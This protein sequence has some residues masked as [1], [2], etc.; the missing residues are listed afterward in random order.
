MRSEAMQS[1]AVKG[2]PA[3]AAAASAEYRAWAAARRRERIAV[4][5]WRVLLVVA[6]LALWEAAPRLGLVNPML[7]SHPSAVWQGFLVLIEEG[8]LGLHV[9]VTVI[10]TIAAFALSMI[11][12][13]AAALALWSWPMVQKVLDPFLVVANALP[14]IALVPIFYIWLGP[15]Q[16]IYAV[17]VAVA[18]FI[19]ILMMYTGFVQTDPNKIKLV[20]T[21]GASRSQILRKVVLPANLAT[22]I[23]TL[24]AN[25]G[26]ALVGVI[27]GEFQ[28]ANAGLG[29]L[30]VYGSQIFRMDM[31][32]AAIV[33]LAVLSLL[34]YL[35]IQLAEARLMRGGAG[36]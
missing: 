35:A 8:D 10:E 32:M 17:A 27:V 23:A 14:K 31:V 1:D 28:S 26:L 29:Y 13:T 18:V 2:S 6:V 24:K 36:H 34:I 20:R 12:G 25:A 30:I 4:L 3:A 9:G 11:I 15:T 22:F 19:T 21:L 16:S 5:G 33:I 7:T